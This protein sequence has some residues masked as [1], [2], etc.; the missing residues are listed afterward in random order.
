MGGEP[1][2]LLAGTERHLE[3]SSVSRA[4]D[5]LHHIAEVEPLVLE[6]EEVRSRDREKHDG[7]HQHPRPDDEW[8]TLLEGTC[9]NTL[10]KG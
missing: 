5:G 9:R 6:F 1:D 8:P 7:P 10:A 3:R 2:R 4:P